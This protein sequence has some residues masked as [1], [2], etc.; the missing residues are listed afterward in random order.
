MSETENRPEERT[1]EPPAKR[2][3][4]WGRIA[5]VAGS[6]LLAGAV[7]AGVGYT[8]V[9]VNGADRDAGAPRWK[10]PKAPAA[11]AEQPE[12]RGLAG[13]LVPYGYDNLLPGPDL[14]EFGRDEQFDGA[15]AT[16]LHKRALSGLPRS[17]RKEL[18]KEIDGWR[19][20]GMAM[21]SYTSGSTSVY[22][23][24]DVYTVGIVLTRMKDREAV[25]DLATYQEGLIEALD[26]FREG[27][28][29]KGHKNAR[30][31]LPPED[32]ESGIDSMECSAYVGDVLVTLTAAGGK[33]LDTKSV[34]TLFGQQLDRIDEP[35]KAV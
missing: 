11:E 7:I 18:E 28:K 33:P 10:L 22:S 27:P 34:A 6:V 29:I 30:C 2:P 15:R 23:P 20:Q 19:V 24:I 13:M 32:E 5:A 17:Q 14:S 16:A 25:R 3:V 8:V 12:A 26:I 35:G 21:R 31:F 4:R 1:P 9:T